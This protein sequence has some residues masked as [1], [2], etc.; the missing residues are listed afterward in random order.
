MFFDKLFRRRKKPD[1][2]DTI[3]SQEE[4]KRLIKSQCSVATFADLKMEDK[5]YR[6]ITP[7]NVHHR[8]NFVRGAY[9]ADFF[10]CDN[11][12]VMAMAQFPRDFLGYVKVGP[13]KEM[14]AVNLFISPDKKV[15]CL[16]PQTGKIEP[17]PK[18]RK[19]YFG[20]FV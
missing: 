5:F 16:H 10:D 15:F 2:S 1:E 9:E 12:A 20:F 19:I 7:E 13:V 3:I 8:F 6:L 11:F 18:D 17:F 4:A 14:H